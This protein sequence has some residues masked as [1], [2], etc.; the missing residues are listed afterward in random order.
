MPIGIQ[1]LATT[2]ESGVIWAF[3]SQLHQR[4][5]RLQETLRLSKWQLENEL[6]YQSCLDRVVGELS[7]SPTQS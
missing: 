2:R 3:K 6:E 4:R 1:V 7:L 5:Y